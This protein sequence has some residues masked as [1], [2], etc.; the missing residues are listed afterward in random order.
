MPLTESSSATQVSG[1]SPS[2]AAQSIYTCGCGLLYGSFSAEASA[3]K[4]SRSPNIVSTFSS[5]CSG[6]AEAS[7]TFSPC[8]LHRAIA[9]RTP[10]NRGLYSSTR[11]MARLIMRAVTS[12]RSG[13]T[14]GWWAYQRSTTIS[15]RSPRVS[16]SS[17]RRLISTPRLAITSSSARSHRGSESIS[18]PSMSK[19]AASILRGVDITTSPYLGV[20]R[21]VLSTSNLAYC[22][23]RAGEIDRQQVDLGTNNASL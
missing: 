18:N 8:A 11:E 13:P 19:I 4:L 20:R 2:F 5:I 6:E 21:T 22:M 9:S 17:L 14:H 16:G 1:S 7:P 23:Q 12:S 10:G 15:M 3:S